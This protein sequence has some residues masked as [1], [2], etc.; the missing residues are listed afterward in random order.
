MFYYNLDVQWQMFHNA[1]YKGSST[2]NRP[3][4][5]RSDHGDDVMMVFGIGL[6]KGNKFIEKK[7]WSNE[8]KELSKR[9]M[10]AWTEFARTGRGNGFSNGAG[11]VKYKT[12]FQVTQGGPSSNSKRLFTSLEH[13]QTLM[14]LLKEKIFKNDSNSGKTIILDPKQLLVKIIIKIYK[15]R[16][17]SEATYICNKM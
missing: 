3:D 14:I 2:H 15:P 9:M 10:T 7:F 5:C 8:E 12:R 1:P 11:S 17:I 13:H 16:G 6:G 4:F